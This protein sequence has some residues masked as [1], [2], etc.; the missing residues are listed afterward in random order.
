MNTIIVMD[1]NKRHVGD[2]QRLDG[3]VFLGYAALYPYCNEKDF[4]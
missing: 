1:W 4:K 3:L 2:E